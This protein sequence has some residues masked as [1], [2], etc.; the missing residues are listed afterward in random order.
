MHSSYKMRADYDD[1]L[2][3]SWLSVRPPGP[4]SH[5]SI[6]AEKDQC[7]PITEIGLYCQT[8]VIWAPNGHSVTTCTHII[9]LVETGA[10]RW[11]NMSKMERK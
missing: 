10:N 11:E 9:H 6:S 8:P 7:Q 3:L 2:A 5:K 1:H 4:D